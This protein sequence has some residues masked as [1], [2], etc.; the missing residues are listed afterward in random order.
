MRIL[1]DIKNVVLK[2]KYILV[3]L[4]YLLPPADRVS[5]PSPPPSP[6]PPLTLDEG[7]KVCPPFFPMT[8]LKAWVGNSAT[9]T[10]MST[11]VEIGVVMTSVL[12]FFPRILT[13]LNQI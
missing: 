12:P 3:S 1:F 13:L 5:G 11:T 9:S 8:E 2:E 4:V 6:Q 7:K 10:P